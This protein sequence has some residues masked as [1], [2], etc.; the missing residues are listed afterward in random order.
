MIHKSYKEKGKA[1]INSCHDRDAFLIN[2]LFF[3]KNQIVNLIEYSILD[4][5]VGWAVDLILS[6]EGMTLYDIVNNS[7]FKVNYKFSNML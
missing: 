6:I 3:W 4:L 5:V 2:L 1:K 7:E